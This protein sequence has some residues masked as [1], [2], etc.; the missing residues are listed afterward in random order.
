MVESKWIRVRAKKHRFKTSFKL[1]DMME[2]KV[3][4]RHGKL[5]KGCK[6][7]EGE[8]K[9]SIIDEVNKTRNNQ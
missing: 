2:I 5:L 1:G 8:I 6:I 9:K 7:C 3:N 4:C